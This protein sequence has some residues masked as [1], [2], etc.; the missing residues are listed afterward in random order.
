MVPIAQVKLL[1]TEAA[2]AI[3]GLV[4]LQTVAVLAVVIT[5]TGS[6]V[7]VIVNGLPTQ[8]PV[9]DVGVTM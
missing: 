7:T 4:P 8:D 2:K 3:F 5:G 9:V 6:T 1:G